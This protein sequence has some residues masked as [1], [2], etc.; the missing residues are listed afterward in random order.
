MLSKSVVKAQKAEVVKK[1]GNASTQ[2]GSTQVQVAL[3]TRRINHLTEHAKKAPK[4]F[5]CRKGLLTLVGQRKRLLTYLK[6]ENEN[7]YL[8]LIQALE[9]RK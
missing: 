6:R 2:T 8:K 4:D 3:I 5:S 7:E 9:L 1:F